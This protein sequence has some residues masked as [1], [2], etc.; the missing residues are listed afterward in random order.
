MSPVHPKVN[1]EHLHA[2]GML[3]SDE[4]RARVLQIQAEFQAFKDTAQE[5]LKNYVAASAEIDRLQNLLAV[6]EQPNLKAE[7]LILDL[8]EDAQ[9]YQANVIRELQALEGVLQGQSSRE[10]TQDLIGAIQAVPL[11]ED[12]TE[13]QGIY[14]EKF[15]EIF[16]VYEENI[17]DNQLMTWANHELDLQTELRD[18]ND[19]LLQQVLKN[20]ADY[21]AENQIELDLDKELNLLKIS[22]RTEGLSFSVLFVAKD[23]GQTAP[24][25]LYR[26][27]GQVLGEGNFG[28]VK[29]CQNLETGEWQA[30]KI[31]EAYARADSKFENEILSVLE[32]YQGEASRGTS[33]KGKYYVVQTLLPGAE[34][35][36]Y[37]LS[38]EAEQLSLASR[39]EITKQAID[40]LETFHEHFLHRDIKPENLIWDEETQTLSLCD[41]G[42]ACRLGEEATEALGSRGYIAPEVL[43]TPDG[44]PMPYS[45][46][47]DIYS[48]GK[49][50]EALFSGV[51]GG[52]P[53]DI[54]ALITEMTVENPAE[55]PG[56]MQA[57]RERVEQVQQAFLSS[58]PQA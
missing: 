41:F 13:L 7:N 47:S 39:L 9:E 21:Q 38:K 49:T 32:R 23:D 48:L 26:G 2:D 30:I 50:F 28:K 20:L 54:R 40:L 14:L 35:G 43:A 58:G 55:R 42:F 52:V 45:K 56:D 18:K 10:F 8:V 11:T 19:A 34:L 37:L 4:E 31:L 17:I 27:K 3:L 6:A 25:V 33:G 22:K 12:A 51:E 44:S 16:E 1:P 15:N 57:M 46:K 53:E 24:Y 36:S 5:A 29:L